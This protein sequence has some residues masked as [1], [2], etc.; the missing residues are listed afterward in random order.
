[1]KAKLAAVAVTAIVVGAALAQGQA[2]AVNLG[3]KDNGKEI[4]VKV[5][6]QVVVT[7]PTNPTTGYQLFMLST[8]NEPWSLTSKKYIQ[9]PRE[10]DEVGVGGKNVYTFTPTKKGQGAISFVSARV[11]DLE[12]TLKSAKPWQVSVTVE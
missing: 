7:L 5:G 8:G 6:Q 11:F 10:A 4:K 2:K 12:N 3:T 1:M 9:D